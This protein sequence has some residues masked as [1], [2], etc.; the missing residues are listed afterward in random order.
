MAYIIIVNPLILSD[1][2]VPASGILFA[3][4]IVSSV[5]CIFMGLYAN[6]PFALAPGMGLNAFV[7]YSLILGQGIA[8]ETAMGAVVISGIIFMLLSLPG[9]NI[10]EKILE[11]IPKPLRLG[12]SAGIG[13]FL[14]FIGFQ[15]GGVIVNS[16]STLVTFGGMSWGVGLF[17][18]GIIITGYLLYKERKGALITGIITI[19]IASVAV[20]ELG[21]A[22]IASIPSSVVEMPDPSLFLRID[23]MS[24]LKIGMIGPLFTL[25][26]TD[27]F[28]SIS[29]FLGVAEAGDFYK[30][31]GKPRNTGKA[32]FVD[33]FA[34]TISGIF[35]TSPATTYIESASGVEE[36]GKSG[37]VAVIVG[38]LFLPFVFF[39]PLVGMIPHVATGAVLVLVGLFMAQSVSKVDWQQY[40]NSIPAFVAMISIPLT[41]SIT[42]GIVMGIITFVVLKAGAR[43]FEDISI[44]LWLIFL[45]SIAVLFLL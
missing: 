25:L 6:L 11:A 42:N 27:M 20:T 7:T 5:A 13:L 17:L 16:K 8:W 14:A 41:Y 43:E 23:I 1:A 44:T 12:V 4:V 35:G 31:D 22:N 29:T 36:G 28:D 38:I 32:L 19:T 9:A 2:G 40:E 39:S 33:G 45:F 10:R 34:T 3:T 15:D 18:I 37:L 30:E 24:A 26:F 21:L